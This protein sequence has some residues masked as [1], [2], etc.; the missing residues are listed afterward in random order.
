L[1]KNNN[2]HT[3]LVESDQIDFAL[4]S[5][6]QTYT[7]HIP[8]IQTE[9]SQLNIITDPLFFNFFKPKTISPKNTDLKTSINT[10]FFY[11]ENRFKSSMT[12]LCTDLLQKQCELK[13]KQLL[14]KLSL[15]TYSLSGFAYAMSEDPGFIVI[16]KRMK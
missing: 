8:V 9:H 13:K 12:T 3:Y 16:Q 6:K 14:H 2:Q 15:A 1:V 7:C 10:K 11:I 5:I 4:T